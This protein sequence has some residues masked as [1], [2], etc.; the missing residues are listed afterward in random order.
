MKRFLGALVPFLL[1]V[2]VYWVSGGE[3]ERG[4]KLATTLSLAIIFSFCGYCTVW[5]R[6]S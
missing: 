3:F 1:V 2:L 4:D 5:I 6:E